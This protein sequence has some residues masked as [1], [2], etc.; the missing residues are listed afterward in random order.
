MDGYR[1]GCVKTAAGDAESPLL[2]RI[3]YEE[4]YMQEHVDWAGRYIAS[5]LIERK[6][7]ALL[8]Y[9]PVMIALATHVCVQIWL[10]AHFQLV[11]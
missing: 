8:I 10:K 4:R 6:P 7:S 3:R 5:W 2:P 11:C 1:G 9:L